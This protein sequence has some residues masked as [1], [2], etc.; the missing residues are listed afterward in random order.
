MSDKNV[1]GTHWEGC[2]QEHHECALAKLAAVKEELAQRNLDAERYLFLKHV[3]P[4]AELPSVFVH[5]QDTWGNWR[6]KHLDETQ[7][8]AAIDAERKSQEPERRPS[9]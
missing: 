3:D 5:K 8:D 2:E 4:D 1:I 9:A 6:Y 7:L